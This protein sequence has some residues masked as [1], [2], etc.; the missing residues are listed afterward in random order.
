MAP[1]LAAIAGAASMRAAM[2]LL[3]SLRSLTRHKSSVPMNSAPVH[4]VLMGLLAAEHPVLFVSRGG[5]GEG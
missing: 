1:F 2:P 5:L 4:A 3:H